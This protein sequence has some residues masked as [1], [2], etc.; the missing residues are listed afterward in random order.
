M[1]YFAHNVPNEPPHKEPVNWLLIIGVSLIAA[2]ALLLAINLLSRK[3][4]VKKPEPEKE[5]ES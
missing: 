2:A 5:E 3:S 1:L 4:F